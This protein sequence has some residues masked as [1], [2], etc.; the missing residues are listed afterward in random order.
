MSV[1]CLEGLNPSQR[2]AVTHADG[3]LLVVAGAGTGKTRTLVA[4]VAHLIHRGVP[5]DRILLLTFTRRAAGEMLRR[6][7]H[8]VGAEEA[9]GVWGGTFHAIAHRLLRIYGRAVGLGDGFTIADQSDAA[10]LI[11]LIRSE[12]GLAGK[13][14]RFPRKETLLRIYS[15]MVNAQ[16]ALTATLEV[17]FPWCQDDGEDLKIVFDHYVERKQKQRI[18]DYD[19]LLLFFSELLTTPSAGRA[20]A[21]RFEH[22]LVD[23]FQDTNKVQAEILLRIRKE[24]RN[25]MVVGDD[26]QSIYS[27]RA[28]T[29]RNILDFP[30]HMP[31]TRVLTLEQNYR[32]TRPILAASNAVMEQAHERYTKNL[33]SDRRSDQKPVLITC[34]D[35]AQQC[36]AVC[37]QILEHYEQGTALLGQAVLF[38]TGHHSAQLE[39]ELTRR[40]LPFRKFGGLRFV[41]AAHIKDMLAILRILE[42]P[43]DEI[44]WFRTLQRLEGIGPRTARRVMDALGVSATRTDSPEGRFAVGSPLRRLIEAPPTVPP[45]AREQFAA[46]RQTIRECLGRTGPSADQAAGE[47]GPVQPR[48]PA[49]VVQVERLRAFFEPIF[50]RV[51]ENPTIRLRDIE[52]LEQIASG[53]RSRDRFIT[54]LTLDPPQATSDL[55]GPPHLDDDYLT[56]STIHSAKGCEWDI[57]HIIHAADGMIPSDM[58]LTDDATKPEA[59]GSGEEEERRLLYVAMTRA[60]DRL[61][62]YFPLRYYHRR[63]VLADAHGYAQISRYLAGDIGT[64]FETR[65]AGEEDEDDDVDHGGVATDP[66]RNVRRLW[67]D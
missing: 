5:P 17:H 45:F 12:L 55:A 39:V 66:Y 54:D 65:R 18:L 16:E 36:E 28:A 27:F 53:Y 8:M 31:G 7:G 43:Y 10:D 37:G 3:P 50:E 56:L 48:E 6:V 33:W 20:V 67:R 1:A 34:F 26:A 19:D 21:K 29:V 41:E 2:E 24:N 25:I 9:R 14:R 4:R 49:L 57:V 23:E 58:A 61:Y 60:K 52:Q 63:F 22:L 51:Y 13:E 40:N 42:N 64:L 35:E 46:L 62:V 30:K 15:R 47:N 38:R 32:S 11:N 44:S 59:A